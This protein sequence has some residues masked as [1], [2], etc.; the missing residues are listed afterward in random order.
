M[1]KRQQTLVQRSV[2]SPPAAPVLLTPRLAIRAFTLDDAAFIVELLNDPGWLRNIGDRGVRTLDD[3]RRYL[4]DGPI[5]AGARQ[6]FSLWAVLRR[7]DPSGAPIGMC[8]L[9]RR[10]GLEHVDLGYAFLPAARGQGFAREAAAAVLKH[11]FERLGLTRI[12]AITAVDNEASGRV[13]EAIGMKFEQ[14]LRVPG[15]A[16]DS[17]LYAADAP[18]R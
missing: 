11:G 3:A 9:V 4:G 17:L 12:V 8:G 6:G 13:L 7:D 18:Q 5:A 14:R 16:D 15:H 2:T 10:E 1:P